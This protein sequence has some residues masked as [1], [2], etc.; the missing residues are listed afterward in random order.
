[1]PSPK[2][3][4][5]EGT[6]NHPRVVARAQL[7]EATIAA[8]IDG[9]VTVDES[10]RIVEWNPASESLFGFARDE[11]L[12]RRFI[13]VSKFEA[14]RSPG[15]V[16]ALSVHG[17][18]DMEA[19]I[20]RRVELQA[21]TRAGESLLIEVET[22]E[23]E[24]EGSLFYSVW[25]RDVTGQ[26]QLREALDLSDRRFEAIVENAS[27]IISML[28]ADGSWLYTSQAGVRQMGYEKGFSPEN[29]LLSLVHP[30]DRHI[31]TTS[32][33]AVMSAHGVV[34]PPTQFRVL[35]VEGEVHWFENV[36]IN[37]IENPAVEAVVIYSRDVCDRHRVLEQLQHRSQQLSTVLDTAG[38]AILIEDA[39]STVFYVN[40][41]FIDMMR[42]Q[43]PREEIVGQPGRWI[44]EHIASLT[45]D[46]E[47]Y[48]RSHEDL[49]NI[50]EPTTYEDIRFADGRNLK[51][52]CRPM[53]QDGSLGS[54]LWWYWDHTREH[55]AVAV[56]E[57]MLKRERHARALIE[58]QNESL[59]QL[60]E[61]K[62]EL[63]ATVSHEIRTPLTAIVSFVELLDDTGIGPLNETQQGFLDTLRSSASRLMTLVDD[64][65]LLVRLDSATLALESIEQDIVEVA[66]SVTASFAPAAEC[67]SIDLV[68]LL[69]PEPVPAVFDPARIGQVVSNL[70]GNAIKFSTG[71]AVT[72]ELETT[73]AEW[74]LTVSDAGIGIPANEQGDIFERFS[75]ASNARSNMIDGSGLG[76][77][78]CRRIIELHGGIIDVESVEGTGSVFTV[79]VPKGM[80]GT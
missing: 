1:M 34:S 3:V 60:G 56:R 45:V 5:T 12:G 80:V 39:D 62:N 29:G 13:S 79:R 28:D 20:G 30:D 55:E 17:R 31:A 43:Q 6:H 76:L 11:V 14:L 42:I 9:L 26:R 63:V 58:K 24:V 37:M 21:E 52:D 33:E 48:M 16:K 54:V 57:R 50:E 40:D 72:V 53:Q 74:I 77:A 61:L 41:A 44:H 4:S 7:A 35:D 59:I 19:I 25:I 8:A 46:P 67:K 64:L 18:I 36:G 68:L 47:E 70:V 27:D 23:F 38:S 10:G 75:R 51:R 32:F 65:L 78:V 22:T 66:R 15:D 73:E 71:G 69:P 2:D 49:R